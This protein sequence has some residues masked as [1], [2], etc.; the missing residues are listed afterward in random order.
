[1]AV[2][3]LVVRMSLAELLGSVIYFAS[4]MGGVPQDIRR[5]VGRMGQVRKMAPTERG[6]ME[7]CGRRRA[8]W[9]EKRTFSFEIVVKVKDWLSETL[10]V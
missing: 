8:V 9:V 5:T 1:M 3:S 4:T 10:L 7:A 2:T 6:S